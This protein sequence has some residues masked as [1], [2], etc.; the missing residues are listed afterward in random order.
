[1]TALA[2]SVIFFAGRSAAQRTADAW[3]VWTFALLCVEI[4]IQNNRRPGNVTQERGTLLGEKPILNLCESHWR[5]TGFVVVSHVVDPRA[6]RIAA[7]QAGIDSETI[8]D[9]LG[10]KP[11]FSRFTLGAHRHFSNLSHSDIPRCN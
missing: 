9:A 3:V 8:A 1:M 7:H 11:T 6:H 10:T 2:E 5:G 4:A